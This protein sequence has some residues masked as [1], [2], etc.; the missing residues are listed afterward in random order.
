MAP[1][2]FF[3]DHLYTHA[4]NLEGVH[5]R[6]RLV[7]EY[8]PVCQ[9]ENHDIIDNGVAPYICI[10]IPPPVGCAPMRSCTVTASLGREQTLNMH[11]GGVCPTFMYIHLYFHAL[12]FLYLLWATAHAR[13]GSVARA[14][15]RSRPTCMTG[16]KPP[17]HVSHGREARTHSTPNSLGAHECLP[18]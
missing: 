12:V 10:Y 8:R 4:L 16:F 17:C 1:Q 13:R 11:G 6:E 7:Y 3:G 5:G 9:L 14:C 2:N 15:S 18:L